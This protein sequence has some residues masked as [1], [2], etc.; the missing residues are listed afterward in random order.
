MPRSKRQ[1]KNQRPEWRVM[2][3]RSR[4]ESQ[5]ANVVEHVEVGSESISM[6]V[7]TEII[8]SSVQETAPLQNPILDLDIALV[9]KIV[10]VSHAKRLEVRQGDHSASA[11]VLP[12][13]RP[14]RAHKPELHQPV[15]AEIHKW[16]A[17]Y[18]APVSLD[19]LA[20]AASDLSLVQPDP[21]W[22]VEQYTPG[23]AETAFQERYRW[24]N[25]I[26]APFIT[27]EHADLGET[28]PRPVQ[29]AEKKP[30][31]AQEIVAFE[32]KV[33]DA[34]EEI[35]ED[36][37]QVITNTEQAWGA[38]VLVPR[39]APLRVVA[40]FLGLALFVS[41]PAGA[42][43][44]GRSLSA[45]WT[46]IEGNSR[47]A[48]DEAKAME[49]GNAAASLA[50]SDRALNRVNV[51][52][53]A[54][55][56]AL[57][58]T[59][60]AYASARALVA[61]G[62]K[63]AEAAGMLA[64]GADKAKDGMI[65]YP[66]ERIRLM[67]TYI[68]AAAPLL[69]DAVS[70]M[71]RVKL[72]S[73]PADVRPQAEEAQELLSKVQTGLRELRVL[74]AFAAAAVGEES[75][76]RYLI[77][78]Q[79]PAE[80]RPTGGFMGSY[81]EV[82]FDRGE[83]KSLSVPGGG[84]YDLQG[85]LK[86]RVRAPGPLRLIADHWEFQDAN[87]FPDFAASA[88]KINW[89]WSQAGQPTLDGILTVN[90][91]LVVNLLKITGPVE[92]PEY[93]KVITSENFMQEAQLAVEVEYDREE[94]K[95]KK[96]IGDL[97][98][99]L[100]ERISKAS[101]D[102]WIDIAKL[103]TDAL[104][105]K[106]IQAWFTRDNEQELSDRFGWSS[107]LKT[108]PGDSL[109]VVNTNIGGQKSDLLI[110]EKVEHAATI[111]PDGSITDK[112]TITRTHRGQKGQ[113]FHGA[114]NVTYL[115][116]YVPQ[117]SEL[118]AASGFNPPAQNLF[119]TPLPNDPEDQDVVANESRP[120]IGP[121]NV[122][123]TDEFGR[124]AFGGW[125]QLEPGETEVTTFEYRLPFTVDEIANRLQE[126]VGRAS[127]A[128]RPAYV[129]QLTSQSGKPERVI[130]SSVALPAEWQVSWANNNQPTIGYDGLWNRDTVV[131]GLL[132]TP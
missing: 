83:I 87:W 39:L 55:S 47:A 129:L 62:Q 3:E 111:A 49:W 117:G 127:S 50:E 112:V 69:E 125:I 72:E 56:Q 107:R 128:R 81:A 52:A 53:V 108:V 31:I 110:D 118:I 66:V 18:D 101:N 8:K 131:A 109:A 99:K 92:M 5:L 27:W 54:V 102:Q 58:Q 13:V 130:K 46:S 132:Q 57:P 67:Q 64:K 88:Q 114:N 23:E 74:S 14:A 65:R 1:P 78:F 34:V 80:L 113:I 30:S 70:S 4:L 42:V 63:A 35:R 121:G 124:T 11:H 59:R 86:A 24:W 48:I 122:R 82:V 38:P 71:S 32:H 119:E 10:R 103:G 20:A 33:E 12:V 97:M 36:V 44:L 40:G 84:P 60:D 116:V 9:Q 29:V 45:S 91:R 94:N 51:L 75:Q 15:M 37:E 17:P 77:V 89:F 95:P 126:G 90:A 85:Q 26:R 22:Y 115:R 41:L 76:R 79:N 61:S 73:L 16:S 19:A 6:S 93:G 68:E 43:S 2:N 120:R 104:V 25:R 7:E 106:D 105:E 98:A 28:K 21:H 96:F 123:I 100:L